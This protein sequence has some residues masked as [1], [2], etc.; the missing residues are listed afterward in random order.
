M[1]SYNPYYEKYLAHYGVLG[2]KW[3][4]RRYQ[5]YPKGSKKKGKFVGKRSK[6]KGMKYIIPLSPA[7]A[8]LTLP[9]NALAY[10]VNT[11]K[12][13]KEEKKLNAYLNQ[14]KTTEDIT[15]KKIKELT[16]EK[17]TKGSLLSMYALFLA[18]ALAAVAEDFIQQ[19]IGESKEKKVLSTLK[20]TDNIDKKTGLPKKKR[21]FTE[22]EDIALV[23]AG[24][25]AKG[26]TNN[27]ANCA[28]VYDLR[29]RGY[30]VAAAK[31]DIGRTTGDIIANYKNQ[32]LKRVV[33]KTLD[34]KYSENVINS[35]LENNPEG[36]RGIAMLEWD[37]GGGHAFNYEV[38]NGNVRFIDAQCGKVIKPTSYIKQSVVFEH[39]RTD[40]NKPN[41]D[42]I[43]ETDTIMRFDEK[44][45]KE[46]E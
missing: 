27:C 35:I 25:R 22:E 31:R 7:S 28:I 46:I 4:V 39:I 26:T 14:L 15:Q 23:N 38:T 18:P 21:E 19:K 44:T 20:Q 6:T 2:M 32:D 17:N 1:Y 9:Y 16:D 5:P 12:R 13:K 41:Y 36:S 30:N 10:T 43:K 33:R 29:R 34:F 40:N 42:R 11:I 24:F 8:L 3:G 45:G 37:T